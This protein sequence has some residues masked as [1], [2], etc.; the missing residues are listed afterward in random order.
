[1]KN[2]ILVF[3][4]ILS[5][6]Q[7]IAAGGTYCVAE[8]DDVKLEVGLVNSRQFGSPLVPNSAIVITIKNEDAKQLTGLEQVRYDH[9][10]EKKEIYSWYNIGNEL[11]IASSKE[12]D[13]SNDGWGIA[14]FNIAGEL[15]EDEYKYFGEFQVSL[16]FQSDGKWLNQKYSGKIECEFE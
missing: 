6:T 1:M 13:I 9:T 4:I 10:Y 16:D 12:M 2:L 5:S 14:S 7:A 11:R 3:A 15:N 8:T